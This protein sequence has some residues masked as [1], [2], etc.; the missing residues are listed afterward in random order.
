MK[1]PEGEMDGALSRAIVL[2][3]LKRN[4]VEIIN[5]QGVYRL[6][7]DSAYEVHLF[8]DPIS[9]KVIQH[10][11]RAFEIDT[12]DFYYPNRKLN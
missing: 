10:L 7:K 6:H 5:D 12:I 1:L 4:R 3:V 2:T 8:S 9:R 11:A